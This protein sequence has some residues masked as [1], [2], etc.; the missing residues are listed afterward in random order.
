MSEIVKTFKFRLVPSA[1]KARKMAQHAGAS[2]FV[3]NQ[4]LDY[5]QKR[6]AEGKKH[7]RFMTKEEGLCVFFR[8]LRD[9]EEYPWLKELSSHT[10]RHSLRRLDIAYN[11]AFGRLKKGGVAGFPK[12]HSKRAD[13]SFTIPEN[14]G[15]QMGK[16][17]L[18]VQKIGWVRMRP[19]RGCDTCGVEGT[20]QMAV[21]KREGGRWF[22]FIQCR[23]NAPAPPPHK[24]GIVGI[25]MG[26]AKPY[27]LSNGKVHE[28]PQYP[29]LEARRQRYQRMMA[30]R[31]RAALVTVGWDGKS[32]TRKAAEQQLG[33]KRK[34][35]AVKAGVG[36]LPHY[37]RRY[38]KAAQRAAKASRRLMNIRHN[39]LHH[40]SSE[41]TAEHG[42]IFVE[43]LKI[44]NMSKS[45]QG[46]ADAPGSQVAQKRGLNRAILNQGWGAMRGM[47]EYK[48]KW[49]GGLVEKV[50]PHNTSRKCAKCGHVAA[51]NRKT[52]SKFLCLNCGHTDNADINA[53]R[54]ILADGNAASAR[55]DGGIS[56]SV[57]R[58][59]IIPQ[60][61]KPRKSPKNQSD[62]ANRVY[63]PLRNGYSVR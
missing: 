45:A 41:I 37:S 26:V 34:A 8:Q 4:G 31:Q 60:G 30:R 1:V 22:A 15:F 59:T 29:R 5:L 58:E 50:S 39:A 61:R 2:R 10:V 25:D 48:A 57:N 24:G 9:S 49:R 51:E 7:V 33:K 54:N 38:E 36:K 46:T 55:G 43:D 35:E 13:E 20:P 6:R 19:H 47:L 52:Q 62:T 56:R 53:A 16:H 40:I 28:L 63:A 14:N 3:W 23:I 21:I 11:T 32:T 42:L 12:F 17:G 44:A 18:K 27:T